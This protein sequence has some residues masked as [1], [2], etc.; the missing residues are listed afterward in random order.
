[1]VSED[2]RAKNKESLKRRKT[3]CHI[4]GEP[5]YCCLELHHVRNK[6]YNISQAVKKLPNELF[7]KELDKCICVC[8][9]CHRKIH[10]NI[11]ELKNE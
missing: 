9:N 5:E 3:K 10:N 11:I 7:I 1:M 6:Q 4:C 8:S 2:V